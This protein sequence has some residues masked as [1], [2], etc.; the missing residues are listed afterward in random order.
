M[1]GGHRLE[2]IEQVIRIM[3]EAGDELLIYTPL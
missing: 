2:G 3:E 1:P